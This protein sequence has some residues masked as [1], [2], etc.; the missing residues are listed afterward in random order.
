VSI[1]YILGTVTTQGAAVRKEDQILAEMEELKKIHKTI[2]PPFK[3]RLWAEMI[4]RT[5][6]LTFHQLLPN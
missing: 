1:L 5:L 4:V 6:D 2:L 3:Y